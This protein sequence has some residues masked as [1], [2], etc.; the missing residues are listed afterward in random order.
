MEETVT[1]KEG[2]FRFRSLPLEDNL[3]FKVDE[4]DQ[5]LELDDFTL[6]I[7]D[8][9]GKKIAQLRRGQNDFFIYKPLGFDTANNLNT[10]EEDSL[11]INISITTDYDLIVVYYDSNQSSVKGND[12]SKL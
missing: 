7:F 10:I 3:L 8:R 11:D 12:V 9:N 6:Y 2:K 5:N 4:M 1:D